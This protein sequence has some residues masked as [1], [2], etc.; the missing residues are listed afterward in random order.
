MHRHQSFCAQFD[1]GPHRLF[2]IHVNFAAGRR[3]V[4]AN[5]QQRDVDPVMLADFPEP[6]KEGAVATMENGPIICRDDESAE[7]AMQIGEKSCAPMITR[8]ERHVDGS[9]FY[10]LPI[11]ELV[12]DVKSEVLHEIA[13]ADWDD[14]GLIGRDFAQGAA[15]EMIEMRVGDE[16]KIDRRQMVNLEAGL[17]QT[18][19]DLQPF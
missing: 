2:R 9:E 10:L 7:P 4:P 13:H 15:I 16:D 17:L 8:G 11:I 12:N 5:G 3:I 1:E 6:R 19:Y 14:D 18:L